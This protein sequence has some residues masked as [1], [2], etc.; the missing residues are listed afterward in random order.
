MGRGWEE[1]GRAGGRNYGFL[2]PFTYVRVSYYDDGLK[3]RM[4]GREGRRRVMFGDLL[5]QIGMPPTLGLLVGRGY[6]RISM[7]CGGFEWRR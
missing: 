3:L 4:A 2:S 7:V 5:L 6:V 1:G